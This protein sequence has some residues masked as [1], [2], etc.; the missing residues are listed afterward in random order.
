MDRMEPQPAKR[1]GPLL[2]QVLQRVGDLVHR[3]P[4]ALKQALA[5]V[6]QRHAA[7]RTVQQP[8]AE[9]FLKQP[10]GVA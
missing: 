1:S 3:W 10:H 4:Q 2:V 8:H 7:R 6:G 5:G 9:P